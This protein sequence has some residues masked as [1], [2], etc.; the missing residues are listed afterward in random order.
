MYMAIDK[1]K[2]KQKLQTL[3]SSFTIQAG[4]P[5]ALYLKQQHFEKAADIFPKLFG[6]NDEAAFLFWCKIPIRFAYT[7]EWYANFNDLLIWF[8]RMLV[9]EKGDYEF[10]LTTDVFLTNIKAR[11]EEGM[12]TIESDW[13]AKRSLQKMADLLNQKG[14]IRLNL[15]DFLKEWKILWMQIEKAIRKADIVLTDEKEQKKI[16][17]MQLIISHIQGQGKMYTT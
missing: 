5:T 11:W 6:E 1:L 12:L 3:K 16:Q 15:Q 10:V 8:E 17:T 9:R 4:H 7:Y 2:I 14:T 13:T